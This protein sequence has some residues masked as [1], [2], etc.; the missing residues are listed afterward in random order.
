M[1]DLLKERCKL[2]AHE[3]PAEFSDYKLVIGTNGLKMKATAPGSTPPK[4]A[5]ALPT[6]GF[7]LP[8]G[9][10]EKTTWHYYGATIGN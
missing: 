8:T 7:R 2:V 10:R 3:E 1:R 4:G 9:P 6:G 5:Y